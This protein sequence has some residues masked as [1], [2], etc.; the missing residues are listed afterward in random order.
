MPRPAPPIEFWDSSALVKV[1]VSE[2]GSDAAADAFEAAPDVAIWWG[3][4]S[5]IVSTL[6]RRRRTG[7]SV[8]EDVDEARA[9]LDELLDANAF[10]VVAPEDRVRDL[11]ITLLARHP[12]KAADSLQLAAA[13]VLRA[14]AAPLLFRAEDRRLRDAARGRGP[15]RPRPLRLVKAP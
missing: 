4:P 12:L 10:T 15:D 3:T 13:F 1:F 2:R 14:P 5:E 9:D 6:E 8:A 7:E 11:S